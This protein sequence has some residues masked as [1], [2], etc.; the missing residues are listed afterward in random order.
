MWSESLG[1]DEVRVDWGTSEW[2]E[3]Q[4]SEAMHICDK[5]NLIPPLFEQCEYSV[6]HC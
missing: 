1:A 3:A 4:L 2:S 6:R 5:L